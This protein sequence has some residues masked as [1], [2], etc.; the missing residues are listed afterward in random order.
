MALKVAFVEAE[1]G[2]VFPVFR[3]VGDYAA[4]SDS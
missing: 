3:P 4:E 1:G 2:R